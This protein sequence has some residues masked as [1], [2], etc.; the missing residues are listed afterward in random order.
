[1]RVIGAIFLMIG[2]LLSLTIL[3]A[4]IGV[5]MM[6]VGALLVAF[7]GRRKTVITNVVTV[8]GVPGPLPKAPSTGPTPLDSK[9]E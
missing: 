7:G 9:L 1:M 5:P 4:F 3:G 6:L 2:F 8:Q